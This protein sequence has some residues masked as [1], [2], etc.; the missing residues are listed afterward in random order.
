MPHPAV[1]INEHWLHAF[2]GVS[3]LGGPPPLIRWAA[4]FGTLLA[5]R[6]KCFDGRPINVIVFAAP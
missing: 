4:L 6:G 2:R 3:S 1:R 5:A